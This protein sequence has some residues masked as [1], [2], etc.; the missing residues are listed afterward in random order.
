MQ[1][2]LSR[3]YEKDVTDGKLTD[4]KGKHL[5]WT[6][7]LPWLKNEHQVSCVPEGTYNFHKKFSQHLGWVYE[8]EKV[9]NRSLIYI[10]SG[11]TTLDLKGCIAVGNKQGTLAIKGKVYPA[12]LKSKDTM[13]KLINLLGT[14]GT[15]TIVEGA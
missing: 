4:E 14:N 15:I 6:L 12:V 9:P 10:H 13:N 7:E 2:T 8:L 5:C 11:N 3:Y 1:L